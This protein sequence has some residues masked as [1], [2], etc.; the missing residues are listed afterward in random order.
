MYEILEN[1]QVMKFD[2]GATYERWVP[3]GMEYEYACDEEGNIIETKKFNLKTG[4]W[5]LI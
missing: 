1:G 5:E 2:K 3:I 4:T